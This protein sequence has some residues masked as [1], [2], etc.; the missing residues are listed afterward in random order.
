MRKELH[1]RTRLNLSR[2]KARSDC[3]LTRRQGC[4]ISAGPKHSREVAGGRTPEARLGVPKRYQCTMLAAG[5]FTGTARVSWCWLMKRR[6]Y[7]PIFEA[8]SK[9]AA[10]AAAS[11]SASGMSALSA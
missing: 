11:W 8:P 6:R 4:A 2:D 10:F 3:P 5:Y 7:A 1:L 9:P